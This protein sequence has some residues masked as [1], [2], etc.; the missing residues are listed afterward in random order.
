MKEQK[1][2]TAVG[3]N[4]LRTTFNEWAKDGWTIVPATLMRANGD[5]MVC[6][7][8]KDIPVKMPCFTESLRVDKI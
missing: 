3:A 1:M 6:V 8:E 2:L 7:M 5:S 4:D